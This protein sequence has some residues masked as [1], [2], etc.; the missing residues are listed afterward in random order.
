MNAFRESRAAAIFDPMRALCVAVLIALAMTA[1]GCASS[2]GTAYYSSG[3]DTYYGR[4]WG[5]GYNDRYRRADLY[6][7]RPRG[8]RGRW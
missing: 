2:S 8:A 1:S 5:A 4:G 7:G 6:Y 3:Y